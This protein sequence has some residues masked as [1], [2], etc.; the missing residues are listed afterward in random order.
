[1]GWIAANNQKKEDIKTSTNMR[2]GERLVMKLLVKGK[3]SPF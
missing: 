3:G 2:F 1:M